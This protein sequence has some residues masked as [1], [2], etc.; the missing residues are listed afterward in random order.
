MTCDLQKSLGE[1]GFTFD[2]SNS[3]LLD[4]IEGPNDVTHG[5][6]TSE[7]KLNFLNHAFYV[8]LLGTSLSA[9]EPPDDSPVRKEDV[10]REL[11][12]C[13]DAQF[14]DMRM[15]MLGLSDEKER[16]LL[17]KF[18]ALSR[19]YRTFLR[20]PKCGAPLRMR[21]SKTG[22]NCLT[23]PRIYYPTCS[24]VAITLVADPTDSYAL[25]VRHKGSPPGV[26]TALAGFAQPGETLDECVRREIAEEV[27]L[28]VSRVTSLN[29]TQPW[30]MPGSSLMCAHYAVTEMSFKVLELFFK[31]ITLG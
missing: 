6:L 1:Y 24:P 2:T 22:A 16:N 28:P 5:L 21:V 12:Q 27:G 17:A 20:C 7:H 11:G 10:L 3:C 15:A 30:P 8:P 9:V 26:F 19:W 23:C 4:A 25:L 13:L 14:I 18:Q 29:R 31:R